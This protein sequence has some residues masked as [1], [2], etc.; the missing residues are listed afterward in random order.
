MDDFPEF[1]YKI[2]DSPMPGYQT[3]KIPGHPTASD[4]ASAAEPHPNDG[5]QTRQR[6]L[7]QVLTWHRYLSWQTATPSSRRVVKA[8][9]HTQRLKVSQS[10]AMVGKP[11]GISMGY[12]QGEV[13]LQR[14]DHR[15][16]HPTCY[17]LCSNRLRTLRPIS[18]WPQVRKPPLPAHV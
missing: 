6:T 2:N 12:T 16:T 15:E 3:R 8:P 11:I 10:D 17:L 18:W 14:N 7:W 13:G 9:T 5:I 1:P 4:N